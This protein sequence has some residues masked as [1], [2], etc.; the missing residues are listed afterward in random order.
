MQEERLTL[1]EDTNSFD[2]KLVACLEITFGI[3]NSIEKRT[4][5]FNNEEAEIE[6]L[7]QHEKV[8]DH[9]D[10]STLSGDTRLSHSS[11]RSFF[12]IVQKQ[13]Y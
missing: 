7:E 12:T 4:A 6:R 5:E 8:H 1:L 13:R 3:I 11:R 10:N 2:D 9:D